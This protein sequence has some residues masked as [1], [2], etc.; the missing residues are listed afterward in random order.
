MGYLDF[1]SGSSATEVRCL[2]QFWIRLKMCVLFCGFCVVFNELYTI[3]RW[4][5]L[6]NF[7]FHR[8]S[9][10]YLD[11]FIYIVESWNSEFS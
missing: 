1:A 6:T 9:D 11:I 5:F 4:Q 8:K 7:I 2:D 3:L 10:S